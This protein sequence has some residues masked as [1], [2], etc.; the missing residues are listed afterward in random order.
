MS[1]TYPKGGDVDPAVAERERLRQ[2]TRELHEAAQGARDA[3]RELRA[4]LAEVDKTAE[5]T[6]LR[7][8]KP[9][10]NEVAESVGKMLPAIEARVD[11]TI[12]HLQEIT[13]ICI[14][15]VQELEATT[16]ARMAGF[17][18]LEATQQHINKEINE[19]IAGL[20]RDQE[21]V[22]D[23]ASHLNPRVRFAQNGSPQIRVMTPESL[24]SFTAAGGDPGLVIDGRT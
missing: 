8:I 20:A 5:A 7:V 18:D 2:Q 3:A 16:V 22:A 11:V 19:A 1:R 21:F 13:E 17:E 15:K 9:L 23:V 12:G 24:N 4:A 10:C 6:I 14:D